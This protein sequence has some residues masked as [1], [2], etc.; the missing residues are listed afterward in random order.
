LIEFDDRHPPDTIEFFSAYRIEVPPRTTYRH[1][2]YDRLRRQI[3]P[4]RVDSLVLI[5]GQPLIEDGY[6]SEEVYLSLLRRLAS[7]YSDYTVVYVPH[8]RERAP[9][10][11]V[12][13]QL[14]L[15][16]ERY[17]D[18]IEIVLA[19]GRRSPRVLTSFFCSALE[20]ARLMFGDA[21][22]LSALRIPEPML[23]TAWPA[24]SAIYDY[25][26]STGIRRLDLE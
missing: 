14:G 4:G 18:P 23:L 22:S 19:T 2:A 26:Y 24:V 11:R 21:M 9:S 13:S 7:E 6:V 20:N 15:Q 16:V 10:Q 3:A 12:V 5:L 25:L 17:V 1:N 8:K